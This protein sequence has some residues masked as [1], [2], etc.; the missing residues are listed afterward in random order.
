MED[1]FIFLKV[2]V[3]GFICFFRFFFSSHK[4]LKGAKKERKVILLVK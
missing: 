2:H 1:I 4:L 3:H